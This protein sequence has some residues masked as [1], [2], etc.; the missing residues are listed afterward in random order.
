V[1]PPY[2]GYEVAYAQCSKCGRFAGSL[3][4]DSNGEMHWLGRGMCEHAPH[5][6]PPATDERVRRALRKPRKRADR[7]ASLRVQPLT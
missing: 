6:R 3:F 4:A 7:P 5:E 2:G 1:T